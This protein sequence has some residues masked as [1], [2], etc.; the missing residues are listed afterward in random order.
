MSGLSLRRT[1]PASTGGLVSY[2]ESTIYLDPQHYTIVGQESV[3][4]HGRSI[5]R[6]AQTLAGQLYESSRQNSH[7]LAQMTLPS[8]K[9]VVSPGAHTLYLQLAAVLH[10][11]NIPV[12][13][14]VSM[15]AHVTDGFAGALSAM[16]PLPGS[17]MPQAM[18]RREEL[19]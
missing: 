12:G 19:P 1:T 14:I 10:D 4:L 18:S 15:D 6:I 16:S 17:G 3:R 8:A 11:M 2:D 13:S 7:P 9:F 5:R